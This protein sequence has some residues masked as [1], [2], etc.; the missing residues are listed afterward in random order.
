MLKTALT[1]EDR[2]DLIRVRVR[3]RKVE[4][5]DNSSRVASRHRRDTQ[6][7]QVATVA[8]MRQYNVS[9]ADAGD[10][11]GGTARSSPRQLLSW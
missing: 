7:H 4:I 2:G 11:I 1:M 3:T 6:G 9:S 5:G 10:T 8:E